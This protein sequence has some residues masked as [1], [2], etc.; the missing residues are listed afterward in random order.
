MGHQC[1]GGQCLKVSVN[2]STGFLGNTLTDMS[3]RARLGGGELR[4]IWQIKERKG[5]NK[6]SHI[7]SNMTGW[8]LFLLEPRGWCGWGYARGEVRPSLTYNSLRYRGHGYGVARGL[9]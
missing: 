5:T 4:I 7:S 6:A 1:I 9:H 3:G 8:R 2:E